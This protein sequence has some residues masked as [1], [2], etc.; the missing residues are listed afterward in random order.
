MRD[1]VKFYGKTD[2]VNGFMLT[3]ALILLKQ[4]TLN[5]EYK[6]INTL[7]AEEYKLIEC[8]GLLNTF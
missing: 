4:L 8:G 3:K 6:C 7:T 5:K 2:M 1:R